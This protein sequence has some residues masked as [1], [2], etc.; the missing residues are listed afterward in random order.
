MCK[1][2]VKLQFQAEVEVIFLVN[3][4]IAYS[5]ISTLRLGVKPFACTMCDMRFFQRYHLQRHSITHTG[6][7][8]LFILN[9]P[10]VT[11]LKDHF[12]FREKISHTGMITDT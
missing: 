4:E 6:M 9:Q 5:N 1:T 2:F 11:F 7:S 8:C 10:Q 3:I 12:I